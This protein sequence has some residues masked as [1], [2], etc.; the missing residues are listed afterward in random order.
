[1]GFDFLDAP[2]PI[3]FAHRGGSESGE[4]ALAAFESAQR[5]GYRYMETDV[6]TTRDGVPMVFH[7]PD[8]L[9]V[10]GRAGDVSDLT[11]AELAEIP[12]PCGNRIPTLAE[13]LDSFPALRF[14]IDLKDSAGVVPVARL[15]AEREALQ[16][17]CITSFSER[18]IAAARR[19]LGPDVCTGLGIAGTLRF[20][21]LSVLPWEHR[22]QKAAVLQLPLH[23]W[24]IPV[25]TPGLVRKAHKAG[26]AVHVWTLNDETSISAALDHGVDGVMTDRL[27]LLKKIF[28]SRGL[29]QSQ[30][31]HSA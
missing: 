22:R 18:R 17:V 27:R 2:V 30:D 24:G 13:A 1:M 23:R 5:L 11:E 25:V 19:L 20:A 10:T 31:T 28:I 26:L 4:N 21:A 12:L 7:D 29:W 16:R 9:R 14:N 8:L 6:R 15:L 3:A